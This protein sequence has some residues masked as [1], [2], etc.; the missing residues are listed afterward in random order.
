MRRVGLITYWYPPNR[1]VGTLRLAKFA[2]YLPDFGWEPVVYTIRPASDLYTRAGTL[3]DE[4]RAGTV[5]RT[6]DPSLN[7]WVYRILRR[8]LGAPATGASPPGLAG[9]PVLRLAHR[10]YRRLLCFPDE[11]WP[12]L[13]GFPM[14]R[15]RLAAE[16]L[17]VLVSSSPPV[18]THVLAARL[19]RQL[20]LPWVADL[21]DPW[22]SW[23]AGSRTRAHRGDRWIAHRTLASASCL[24]SPSAP[25]CAALSARHGVPA[26]FVP[27]GFDPDDVS[28]AERRVVAFDRRRWVMAHTGSIFEDG[29]DPTW[30]FEA[31]SRLLSA[32]ALQLG[33]VLTIWCGRNLD[34][35][36][37]VLL[38][39]P[40][41]APAVE[42]RGEVGYEES[43]AVQ[44]AASAL[45]LL[46]DPAPS[47]RARL[48]AKIYEYLAAGR[49]ILARASPDGAVAAL[50]RETGAG[51]VVT[52]VEEAVPA[53]ARLIDR[54]RASAPPAA[55]VPPDVLARYTRRATT[56][57]LASVLDRVV[58]GARAASEAARSRMPVGA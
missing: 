55:G 42:L 38:R 23:P 3:P 24:T 43:L 17:D 58:E 26:A 20:G 54:W 34:I 25:E 6:A 11:C 18:T 35:V 8:A 44:R 10:L 19:A 32:G 1:T 5:M 57:R 48:P 12:W 47:A 16:R 31:L 52:T 13:L 41:L 15:A 2:K 50:L 45:L 46:E 14:H 9:S 40:D 36:A 56:A 51:T 27:N 4:C 37:R 30:L 49:P 39:H 21:R 28:H 29:R 33:E 53:M 22:A 7:V